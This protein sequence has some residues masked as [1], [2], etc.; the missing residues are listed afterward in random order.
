[1]PQ[2]PN[3]PKRE[4]SDKR[5]LNSREAMPGNNKKNSLEKLGIYIGLLAI[6][7]AIMSTILMYSP[8]LQSLFIHW[9][10]G[11]SL[12][13]RIIL[14]T[15]LMRIPQFLLPVTLV[16]G[17]TCFKR[18]LRKAGWYSIIGSIFSCLYFFFLFL[19]YLQNG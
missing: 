17:I 3:L 2:S 10:N 14:L 8:A 6:I 18:G 11:I 5:P 7:S 9:T 19:H 4:T 16:L 12:T 13:W 1:M 15:Q